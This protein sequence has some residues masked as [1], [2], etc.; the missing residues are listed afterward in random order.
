MDDD[1]EALLLQVAS[2]GTKPI[3]SQ[4]AVLR[5]DEQLQ[6]VKRARN[7]KIASTS[8]SVAV[9]VRNGLAQLRSIAKEHIRPL[10][11]FGTVRTSENAN[12]VLRTDNV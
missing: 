4:L 1:S 11:A 10:G 8:G 2:D 12:L 7:A 3:V 5:Q 9:R 6:A